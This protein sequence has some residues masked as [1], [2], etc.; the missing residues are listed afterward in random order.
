MRMNRLAERETGT[1]MTAQVMPGLDPWHADPVARRFMATQPT[2]RVQLRHKTFS[3]A[4]LFSGVDG[5]A[6]VMQTPD[7]RVLALDY[8][9]PDELDARWNETLRHYAGRI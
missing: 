1:T 3:E 6:I 7:K 4:I 5:G 2:E 8:C 9:D